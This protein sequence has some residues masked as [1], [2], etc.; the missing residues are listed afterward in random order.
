MLR[1]CKRSNLPEPFKVTHN[2]SVKRDQELVTL[3][4]PAYNAEAG[5]TY[6]IAAWPDQADS[7]KQAVEAI[8]E[9]NAGATLAIEHTLLQPFVDERED[10]QRF[11]TAIA[12]LDQDLSL[13]LPGHYVTISTEVG[14]VPKGVDWT[15]VCGSLRTWLQAHLSSF[16][17]GTS[18]HKVPGLPF[19][20]LVTVEKTVNEVFRPAGYFF[21]ARSLPSDSLDDVMKVALARKLPKLVGTQ[22]DRCIL[23]LEKADVVHGFARLRKAIDNVRPEFPQLAHVDEIWVAVTPAWETES[24]IWFYE[25]CPKLGRRRLKVPAQVGSVTSGNA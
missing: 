10:S 18:R 3:F 5:S 22:A 1:P 20:L 13:C 15:Q 25:L 21:V 16:P 19:E 11:L 8:A 6:K 17:E 24:V 12:P 7:T 4:V 9:D 23:L 14:A 2:Q